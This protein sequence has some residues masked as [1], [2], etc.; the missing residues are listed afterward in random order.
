MTKA[1]KNILRNDIFLPHNRAVSLI[2]MKSSALL[3]ESPAPVAIEYMQQTIMMH[4]DRKRI[5]DKLFPAAARIFVS[6]P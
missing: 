4:I 2:M 3:M 6:M 1:Q 5:A